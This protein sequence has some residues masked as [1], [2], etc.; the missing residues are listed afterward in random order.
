MV[1]LTA[2]F[3]GVGSSTNDELWRFDE[4]LLRKQ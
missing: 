1:C 3:H 2:L 4:E